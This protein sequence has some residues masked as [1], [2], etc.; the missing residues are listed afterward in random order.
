[1]HVLRNGT[2]PLSLEYVL[3]YEMFEHGS[4]QFQF[5]ITTGGKNDWEMFVVVEL[6][7]KNN[8]Q[9]KVTKKKRT[10]QVEEN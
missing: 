5:R 8:N 2:H 1:M 10:S 9:P 7:G 4:K 6:W 3:L